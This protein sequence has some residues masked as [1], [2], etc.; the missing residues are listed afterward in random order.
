MGIR[1]CDKIED[2][3]LPEKREGDS[4]VRVRNKSAFELPRDEF[5]A[6]EAAIGESKRP[7]LF[8]TEGANRIRDEWAS[9]HDDAKSR[10]ESVDYFGGPP[11]KASDN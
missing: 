4:Q 5:V 8:T 2:E 1:A 11:Q 7:L 10:F 9:L 3:R 6:Q